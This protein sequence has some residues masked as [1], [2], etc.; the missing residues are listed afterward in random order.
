MMRFAA[1]SHQ[2]QM[3]ESCVISVMLSLN[4]TAWQRVICAACGRIWPASSRS[5]EQ[6]SGFSWQYSFVFAVFYKTVLLRLLGSIPV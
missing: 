3:G 4:C 6:A 5:L 1:L 2:S